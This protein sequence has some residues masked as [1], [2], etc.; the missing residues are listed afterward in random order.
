MPRKQSSTPAL[1]YGLHSERYANPVVMPDAHRHDEV[2]INF[3]REGRLDYL[4]NG[5]V[6]CIEAGRLLVFWAAAPHQLLRAERARDFFWITVPLAWVMAWSLPEKVLGR[7][8]AGEPWLSDRT[9]PMDAGRVE[10]WHDAL[11]GGDPG[12]ERPVTLE[13]EARLLRLALETKSGGAPRATSTPGPTRKVARM[14]RCLAL[15][16]TEPL[17]ADDIAATAG[18]HPNYAMS[19]FRAHCG[20]TLIECLTQHRVAHAKRLLLTTNLKIIDV[21]LASGF[22]SSSRFYAAFAEHCGQSPR[23]FRR[24][25]RDSS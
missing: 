19:L 17:T 9:D 11:R 23:A 13:I 22:G 24:R 20:R 18:L 8:L 21:A 14:A 4:L 10:S 5:T 12:W 3:V 7:L 25:I 2:E 15:R 16:Y 1:D 6:R